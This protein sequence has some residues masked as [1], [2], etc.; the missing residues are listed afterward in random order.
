MGLQG[1]SDGLGLVLWCRQPFPPGF[2]RLPQK[3]FMHRFYGFLFIV[4]A[5]GLIIG[6]FILF[7]DDDRGMVVRHEIL[8][9]KYPSKPSVSIGERMD[10]FQTDVEVGCDR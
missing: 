10:V 9:E 1:F 2:F 6:F 3:K 4:E 8:V 5:Q 7:E